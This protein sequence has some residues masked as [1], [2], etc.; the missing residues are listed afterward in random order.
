MD[1]MKR[2]RLQA[3][4]VDVDEA[5]ER[6]LQNEALLMK[7]LARLPADPTFGQLCAAMDAGDVQAAFAAAHTLKGLAGNLSLRRLHQAVSRQVELLRGGGLAAAAEL[8]PEIREAWQAAAS[9]AAEN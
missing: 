9:A 1:P 6:F 3:A 7:F 5:L 2:A 4:G 8:M